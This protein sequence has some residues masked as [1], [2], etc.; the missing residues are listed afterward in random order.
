MTN[1]GFTVRNVIEEKEVRLNFPSFIE[2]KQ[3]LPVE[4]VLRGRK[5]ASL[6]IHVEGAIGCIKKTTE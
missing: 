1:H 6:C 3:Q 5:I 2:N 4:E